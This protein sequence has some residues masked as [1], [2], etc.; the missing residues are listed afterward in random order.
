MEIRACKPG[1][2]QMSRGGRVGRIGHRDIS[3]FYFLGGSSDRRCARDRAGPAPGRWRF[4]T[5]TGSGGL[6]W[7]M[8]LRLSRKADAVLSRSAPP[9]G[10]VTSERPE[11]SMIR[12]Q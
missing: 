4:S 9:G 5:L 2:C 12:R 6:L 8:R 11:S 10:L 1:R 7:C 3:R